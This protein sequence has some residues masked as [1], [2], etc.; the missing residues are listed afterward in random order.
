MVATSYR[1]GTGSRVHN[2]AVML[3]VVR[4]QVQRSPLKPG[5]APRRRYDPAP[6]QQVTALEVTQDGAVGIA[7]DGERILDVHHRRHH[8]TRDPKGRGGISVMGTGDYRVLRERYGPHL[9]DGIAGES[10][11]VEADPGLAGLAL[12]D[13]AELQ[14]SGETLSLQEFRVANP[15]V[16]FTR[17]CLGLAPDSPVD[18]ELRQA[19]ADLGGGARGYR[20]RAAGPGTVRL[21]DRLLVREPNA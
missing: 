11:L 19:L 20:A 12:P 6:L 10:V 1:N 2:G 3:T 9:V 13:S 18:D 7:A 15:C 17:F 21:G 14:S 8:R 16:E 4:M 5:T